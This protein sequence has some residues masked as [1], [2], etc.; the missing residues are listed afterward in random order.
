FRWNTPR[1]QALSS[2]TSDARGL[3]AFD[4]LDGNH[5]YALHLKHKDQ[6]LS[7]AHNLNA[8]RYDTTPRR[9]QH[10]AFFT[11][12][13]LYRPGQT[14]HFTAL[15]VDLDPNND[16]YK[17]LANHKITAVFHDPN[18]KEVA[19]KE[20]VTNEYGSAGGTFTAPSDRLRGRFTI[21]V[22]GAAQGQTSFNVEEYK[23]PKFQVA[24]EKPKVAARLN[25]PVT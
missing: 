12:R 16:N 8:N 11:D 6:E 18:H 15:V 1:Y 21:R 22:A 13:S 7:S 23:R 24:V 3:F 19:R 9:R 20:L 4:N 25:G 5:N 10:T 2:T 17:T 14:V